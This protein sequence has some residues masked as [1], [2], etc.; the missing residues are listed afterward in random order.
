MCAGK[1]IYDILIDID[2]SGVGNTVTKYTEECLL[3]S[4][5][6]HF[7]ITQCLGVCRI[8]KYRLPILV[9]EK[10]ETNLHDFLE[11]VPNISLQLKLSI[12]TDVS[13]GLLYLHSHDP[14]VI[15]RDLTAKNVLL[16]RTLVAKITD[17][18]NSRLLN[19]FPQGNQHLTRNPGTPLYMPPE[20]ANS[21]YG[22]RLDVFSFG[23]LALFVLLQVNSY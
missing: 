8:S 10:L 13:N 5:L 4:S 6:T 3:M 21:G 7:N 14:Q 9:M 22:P 2:G 18:G 15:H 20:A 11:N 23:H 17:F 16:T 12:L 1:I 19:L